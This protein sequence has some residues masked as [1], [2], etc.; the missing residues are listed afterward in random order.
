MN[1]LKNTLKVVIS[2]AILSVLAACASNTERLTVDQMLQDKGLVKGESVDRISRFRVNGWETLDDQNLIIKAGVND[3][4]LITLRTFCLNLE[5][6]FS[7]G[8][9][10]RFSSVDRFDHII[11][12]RS[13][14]SPERCQIDEIFA[15]DAVSIE[16]NTEKA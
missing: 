4:Y 5:D 1:A 9:S 15:L 11:V 14:T 13:N 10:N 16:G 2:T 3:E 8:V 6:A 7:I 12:R